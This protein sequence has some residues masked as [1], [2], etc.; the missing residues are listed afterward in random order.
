MVPPSAGSVTALGS[1]SV[2]AVQG[3]EQVGEVGLWESLVLSAP[4]L[5]H[6]RLAPQGRDLG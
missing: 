6:T 3:A 5:L 2:P 4:H 1:G